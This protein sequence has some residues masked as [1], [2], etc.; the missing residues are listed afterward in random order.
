MPINNVDCTERLCLAV[1]RYD[2]FLL[3]ISEGGESNVLIAVSWF[4]KQVNLII[5]ACH[6]GMLQTCPGGMPKR[7]H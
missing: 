6:H 4:H 2:R 1:V 3:H 5:T 7:R